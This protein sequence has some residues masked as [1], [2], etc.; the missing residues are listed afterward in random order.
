MQAGD[1]TSPKPVR[2]P[3]FPEFVALVAMMMALNALAIDMML[4]ALPAIG[5]ALSVASE[6]SRQ[7]VI[8]AYL[9][10]FG[11]AQ[12]IYGPLA[13]RYGR[14]PVLMVGLGLYVLFSV[15]AA[16]TTTFEALILARLGTGLGAAALRVLAVS[17]VRDRY[18]GRT[19]ARVMSLS[20]LV[21]LGVPILAPTLGQLVLF[22][23]PWR[24]I[25]GVL[26]LAG[27]GF[28][29]WALIRLPE[30]L[31]PEN[32]LP[33][34]LGR[35]AEAFRAVLSDRLSVGYTLA[36]T[37]ITGALF[38]FIN[39]SQQIFFDVFQQPGLFTTV[40]GLMAAGIAVASLTNARLVE[41]LGSR[42]L[43]H[44]ALIGFI[45]SAAVHA[46]VALS[47][48]ESL[49]SFAVLQGLTMF[50]FGFIAGNFGAL[51][52]NN[53]GRIAGTASSVQ[54]FVSTT[55]GSLTGFLI[56]QSFD[57]TAAPMTIGITTCGILALVAVMVAER[58][59]LFSTIETESRPA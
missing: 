8:T 36:M 11:V 46:G 51:A 25:F 12:L 47:G 56:G 34:R 50:C 17:I 4:P 28:M 29:V 49:I 59:K 10:G 57:G 27:S 24:W 13:D 20:F 52:M 55:F 14:K 7:W 18:S 54:G 30:T 2:G 33:I 41:R 22:V 43:S 37:A 35:I 16:F 26:A 5:E 38:A 45:T 32:R 48:N 23:A 19:M 3:G 44:L 21:F 58:G 31:A 1:V 9:L 39:S 6:N 40:F 15:A 53:M 42:R